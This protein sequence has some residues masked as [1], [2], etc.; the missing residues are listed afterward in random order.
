MVVAREREFEDGAPKGV[1]SIVGGRQATRSA[2]LRLRVPA[3]YQGSKDSIRRR[4]APSLIMLMLVLAVPSR[5][6][7]SDTTSDSRTVD[8]EIG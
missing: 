8:R 6:V 7:Q 2:S 5:F 3:A 4:S 1:H